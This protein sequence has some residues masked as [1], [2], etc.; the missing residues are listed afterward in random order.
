EQKVVAAGRGDLQ[1]TA[2][3]RLTANV[4]EIRCFHTA[5]L[6]R[7][8]RIVR[9]RNRAGE[10]RTSS[11]KEE[12]LLQVSRDARLDPSNHRGFSGDRRGANDSCKPLL[13]RRQ[14]DR[15]DPPDGAQGPF[16]RQL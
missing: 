8:R 4:R 2:A 15:Q 5:W 11:G 6:P 14:R 7:Q 12:G 10:I 13:P 1:R 9:W 3:C 16:E